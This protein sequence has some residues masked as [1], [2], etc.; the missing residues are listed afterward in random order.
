MIPNEIIDRILDRADIVEIMSAYLPLKR[1]GQNFKARCPFHDEKTPSFTVSP[2]KQIYHCFGCGAGGNVIGFLMKH[3]KME[4]MEAIRFL[5]DKTGVALPKP[6]ISDRAG[7]SFAEKLFFVNN[8]ACDYY[9]DNL[10]KPCG[11]AAFDYFIKRG[12]NE[13]TMKLFRLGYAEDSWQGFLNYAR[14]KSI[15]E[16]TLE[17]AGIILQNPDTKNRYDRFRNRAIFPICDPRGKVLGFGGRA[18]DDRNPPKYLNSPETHIYSK[19]RNLYGLNVSRDAIRKQDYV[20]IVEGYFDLILPYQNEIRNIVATLGTALT[21]EQIRTLKR[22]T[23]NVVMVYDSDAAGEEAALRGMELL[24]EE[25]MNVRIAIL[26]KGNDPDSFVRSAGR[27][28]FMKMLKES[29]DFFDYKLKSLTV[30]FRKDDPR[31]K[32][33]IAGEM[34]PTLSK[35]KNAVLKSGYLRK[36]AEELSVD[37]DSIRTELGRLKRGR[38]GAARLSESEN[39]EKMPVFAETTLL[40]ALLEDASRAQRI[41]TELGFDIFNDEVV[42]SII[43]KMCELHEKGREVTP[44]RLISCFGDARVGRVVSE[45]ASIAETLENREKVIEDCLR[46]IKKSNLK[47]LLSGIQFKIK[48]AESALDS[49]GVKRL[50]SEY[51]ELIKAATAE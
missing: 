6:Q 25:D 2:S 34:L 8:T 43:R 46:H 28:G 24:L 20:I 9:R 39:S 19:G 29:K 10:K 51:S 22:L 26:P 36:I 21:G 17:K 3:E 37:E 40:A 31:G 14:A 12:L 4:F 35:V 41:K 15:D 27:P 49:D 23:K 32:A 5:A 7:S 50:I 33:R 1:A 30:K 16:A 42:G 38:G 48:E 13:R 11:K 44:S 47:K 45:A 18:M